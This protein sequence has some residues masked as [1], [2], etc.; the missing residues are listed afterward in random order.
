MEDF[1]N[2]AK[3][4]DMWYTNSRPSFYKR[5]W[6]NSLVRLCAVFDKVMN[7]N[8]QMRWFF[9]KWPKNMVSHH[10]FVFFV[11]FLDS[12]WNFSLEKWYNTYI[13]YVYVLYLIRWWTAICK[14]DDFFKKWPKTWFLIIIL[15]F[16]L[17]FGFLIKF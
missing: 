1:G 17:F 15:Y 2:G 6:V 16:F 11:V 5:N 8:M 10:Y 13:Q 7:C 9:K 14:W 3:S 12:S 4:F